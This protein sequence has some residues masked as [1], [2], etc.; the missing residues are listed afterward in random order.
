MSNSG[1]LFDVLDFTHS[2]KPIRDSWTALFLLIVLQGCSNK[3]SELESIFTK[4]LIQHKT[5]SVL[6][7]DLRTIFGT[8]WKKACLQ[9]PYTL[10]KHLEKMVGENVK[11]YDGISDDRYILWVFYTD[12]HTS[13][14]EIERIK[15]MEYR[16]KGTGCTSFQQP[17][18]YF[19]VD[20]GE[21]K[22]FLNNTGELK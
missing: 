20:G 10:Q 6:S 15:V 2:A 12:G 5:D 13:R 8:Q 21:K 14:V 1:N 4:E 9:G 3:D 7:I 22:Y 19:D 16:H 11:D 18:L 17:F